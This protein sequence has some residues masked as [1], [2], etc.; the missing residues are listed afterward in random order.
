MP[1]A[2]SAT[3]RSGRM[4]VG[5]DERQHVVDE[6]RQQ[7]VAR[8]AGRRAARRR[9]PWPSSTVLATRLDLAEPG[10][11]TDR[12]GA[13]EAQ[14]DAVVLGRVVRRGEH[15]ARGGRALPEA[16]YMRSVE[17]SPRSTTSTPCS[18]TPSV[19]AVDERRPRRAHVAADEHARRAGEAGEGDA[20][21]MGDS[22]LS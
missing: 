12:A 6:R 18:S 17:A 16:K 5:V 3:T 10:V 20:E 9:G 19:N 4:R 2:V 11:D 13:G 15:R 1:L 21:R 7:V 22:A 8:C 14:L